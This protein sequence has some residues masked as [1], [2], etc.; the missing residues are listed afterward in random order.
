MS[1]RRVS[2]ILFSLFSFFIITPIVLVIMGS[3]GKLWYGTI[4]PTGI[5]LRW[6]EKLFT[7]FFYT[8][9]MIM[10]LFIG[11]LTVLVTLSIGLPAVYAIYNSTSKKAKTLFDVI[12]MVPIAVPPLVIALGLITFYNRKPFNLIGTWEIL[13]LAHVMFTIPFMVRPIMSNLRQINWRELSEA[14]D[15]MGAG[16][17]HKV[18][19]ILIPNLMPGIVSG[20]LMVFAMSLGEFQLAVL[21]TG[22]RTQT[23]PVVLQQAFYQ[24]TGFACASTS[25][26]IICALSV[27]WLVTFILGGRGEKEKMFTI[28]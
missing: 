6:Y 7:E 15:S 10:S 17:W 27:L 25:L 5:T 8:R 14:S 4:L 12:T 20:S 11:S 22:F 26:L 2:Y 24:A 19:K 9:A 23:F 16:P 3:F 1:W 13:L 28:G 21:L 18:L